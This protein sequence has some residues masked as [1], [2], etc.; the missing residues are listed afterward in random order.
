VY[1]PCVCLFHICARQARAALT[2]TADQLAR[3][4]QVIE[5]EI[6]PKTGLGVAKG[7]KVFGAAVL[8]PSL[9]T[10]IADTNHETD[11]PLFHGEVYTQK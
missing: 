11:S 3:L 1:V 9:E 10:V 2:A 7:D 5:A 6:L 4:L 8:S